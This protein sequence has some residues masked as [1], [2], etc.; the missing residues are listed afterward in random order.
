MAAPVTLLMRLRHPSLELQIARENF[1]HKGDR[2]RIDVY[3]LIQQPYMLF[4]IFVSV[5]VMHTCNESPP[6]KP[7]SDPNGKPDDD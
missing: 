2:A 5:V 1:L 4:V 3:K 7:D 6:Y